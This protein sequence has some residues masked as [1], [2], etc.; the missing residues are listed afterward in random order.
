MG[1]LPLTDDERS[2]LLVH[3]EDTIE[4]VPCTVT[5]GMPIE[6]R[7]SEFSCCSVEDEKIYTFWANNDLCTTGGE[8]LLILYRAN[9]IKRVQLM[10]G[11][12]M[13]SG[14]YIEPNYWQW[15]R[16]IW[17]GW[18]SARNYG[19]LIFLVIAAATIVGAIPIVYQYFADRGR[20]RASITWFD[21]PNT[22]RHVGPE[23]I[24]A[25]AKIVKSYQ[26]NENGCRSAFSSLFRQDTRM[27]N[28]G[29]LR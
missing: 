2:I 24:D 18:A 7:R 20:H 1:L 19:K 10:A 9:S 17:R 14:I 21:V 25:L 23:R 27:D 3:P 22:R 29:L 8:V 5:K 11:I 6:D 15:R 28:D 13:K 26:L 16:P 4:I 12:G